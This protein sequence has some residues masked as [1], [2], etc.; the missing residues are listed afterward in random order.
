MKRSLLVIILSL[1]TAVWSIGQGVP[2]RARVKE[3]G[4]AI[5]ATDL[6]DFEAK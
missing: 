1:L 6:S 3:T 5:M 2:E 4:K